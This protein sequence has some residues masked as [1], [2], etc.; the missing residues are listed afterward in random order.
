VS[1]GRTP[2]EAVENI[3]S[4]RRKAEFC[5]VDSVDALRELRSSERSGDWRT[6]NPSGTTNANM[7][8]RV[9]NAYW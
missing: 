5:W 1:N 9:R 6:D 4:I 7:L 8:V 2:P 3:L